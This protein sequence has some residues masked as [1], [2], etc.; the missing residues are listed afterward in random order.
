MH[1]NNSDFKKALSY[2]KKYHK[3]ST[4]VDNKEGITNALAAIASTYQ[5]MESISLAIETLEDLLQQA[6]ANSNA[7]AQAGAALNL[8]LLY[9]QQGSHKQSVE[10]LEKHFNL[11]R[12]LGDR[13]LLDAAR[14]NLGVAQANCTVDEFVDIVSDNLPALLIW[15]NK[16]S[17]WR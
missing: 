7:S 1:F 11:A 4:D 15:K 8:G 17:K 16:R 12:N 13:G 10:N 3:L 5:A 6:E 14:V 2:Q 9:H